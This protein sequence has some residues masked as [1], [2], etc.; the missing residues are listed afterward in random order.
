MHENS[1]FHSV[2]STKSKPTARTEHRTMPRPPSPRVPVGCAMTGAIRGGVGP[3]PNSDPNDAAACAAGAPATRASRLRALPRL[4]G[5][6]RRRAPPT[7]A[8]ARSWCAHGARQPRRD[9]VS[10]ALFAGCLSSLPRAMVYCQPH[11]RLRRD[12]RRAAAPEALN[13]A[14]TGLHRLH[15]ATRSRWRPCDTMDWLH[16]GQTDRNLTERR[17]DRYSGIVRAMVRLV[18]SGLW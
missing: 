18:R 1:V 4:Q 7:T 16:K 8:C 11:R 2:S 9:Q 17:I 12:R 3:N 13:G 6:A 15:R 10:T 5:A 14:A